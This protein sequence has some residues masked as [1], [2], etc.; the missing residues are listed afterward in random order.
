[1]AVTMIDA[2]NVERTEFENSHLLAKLKKA[3]IAARIWTG[4]EDQSSILH[5]VT[6]FDLDVPQ[7]YDQVKADYD[8][9]RNAIRNQ[10]FESLTGKMG[11]Y[12]QPRTKGPG[13][14]SV[15]R[16]FYART[17]F[18]KKFIFSKL[19]SLRAWRK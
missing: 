1:M 2:Y 3:V 12:I 10:G 15:S 13:H 5:S 17:E 4:Q 7:I 8:L 16:A 19:G 11:V 6:T 9:V 18:L 14:G